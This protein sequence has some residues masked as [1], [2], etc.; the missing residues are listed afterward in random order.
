MKNLERREFFKLTALATGGFMLGTEVNGESGAPAGAVFAP[1]AFI[2]ISSDGSITLVAHMPDMGQGVKTSLPMLIAEELEVDWEEVAIEQVVANEKI[3][4][5][6]T[7]GGSQSV[8][9]NFIRLRQ[10][11]AA[12]KEML[13]RAAA[14]EWGVSADQCIAESGTV[15]LASGEK[16]L[17]YGELAPKAALLEAPNPKKVSLKDAKDFK[18]LGKRIGGVDNKAM[19]TGQPL[20]GIDQ[21]QPGLK[22][23]SFLRCPVFG[24]AV[25]EANLEEVKGLP[26][27]SDVFRSHSIGS[28]LCRG[29]RG[30]GFYLASDGG[31]EGSQ[32]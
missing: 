7:A 10:L 18:L 17:T 26:G 30:C 14:E 9:A 8:P 15:K 19:V 29:G 20:Y 25:K 13:V 31:H 6:Q 1:N 22:Y 3:Y 27:V 28:G 16:V 32:G 11:G 5:R 12:A 2:K 23:A 24:G 21:V 4:G